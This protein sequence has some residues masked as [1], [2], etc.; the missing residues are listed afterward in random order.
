MD[1]FARQGLTIL[2]RVL[3]EIMPLNATR[4]RDLPVACRELSALLTTER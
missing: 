4:R 3:D 2:W 1:S